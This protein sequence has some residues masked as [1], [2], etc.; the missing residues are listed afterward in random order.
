MPKNNY[1]ITVEYDGTDLYG[2]QSQASGRTV[3]DEIQQALKKIFN[4]QK[5]SLIGSGRTDSGVHALGQV[6]NI[7]IDSDMDSKE[8]M[9]ALN[10]N[11][12]SNIYIKN[13][14]I[15]DLD[16][17]SRFSAIKRQYKYIIRSI[18]SPFYKS[19]SWVIDGFKLDKNLLNQCAE[20]LIGKHDFTNYSKDNPDIEN[21]ICEIY[22]SNWEYS[23]NLYLFR[24]KANRF[25]HHMVRYLIGTMVE[26]GKLNVKI[27]GNNKPEDLT[28][29]DCIV[30]I[31]RKKQKG[32]K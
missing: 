4:G 17:H 25:L 15:A 16:F 27:Y 9:S 26:V 18:Y 10:G 11:L 24:I 23:D 31:N 12:E 2:W 5:I 28:I 1:K 14:E 7:I 13:C 19:S 29:E 21:R 22:E 32:N 30:M 20:S 6:A 3:Q 8:F